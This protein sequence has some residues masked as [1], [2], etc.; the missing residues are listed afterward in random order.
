MKTSCSCTA[1]YTRYVLQQR[2]TISIMYPKLDEAVT[3]ENSCISKLS[4]G[5]EIRKN[6]HNTLINRYAQT[7]PNC[8]QLYEHITD[9]SLCSILSVVLNQRHLISN[10]GSSIYILDGPELHKLKN[11]VTQSH[12]WSM[13]TQI[14]L[15]VPSG[16]R[17]L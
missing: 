2:C 10:G 13:N 15:V 4:S 14:T 5:R 3:Q 6:M 8:I 1:A 11:L 16:L 12:I 7:Y 9:Y 17:W